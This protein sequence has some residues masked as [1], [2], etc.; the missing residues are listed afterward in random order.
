MPILG[1]TTVRDSV[2]LIADSFLDPFAHVTIRENELF[3]ISGNNLDYFSVKSTDAVDFRSD[4]ILNFDSL[5]KNSIDLY[6]SFKSI[7]LQDR[8][9]KI[10][11]SDEDRDDWGNFDN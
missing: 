9:N 11:N 10:N 6:S 2:G 8:E 5:E 4:N 7:Y 3:G 1:P